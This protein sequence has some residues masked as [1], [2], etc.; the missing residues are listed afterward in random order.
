M[1]EEG[2]SIYV[3]N[4]QGGVPR[5]LTGEDSS[6]EMRPSYSR[7]GKWIYFG[8]NRSGQ[9]QVWKAHAEG[10]AA[11]QVT[12]RG[13]R[14]A[15]ESADGKFV[16]Y[17]KEFPI[18]GIW[19]VPA[20]GGE[21]TAVLDRG[22]QGVWALL[23]NG[24]CCWGGQLATMRPAVSVPAILFFPFDTGVIR[25]VT[26]LPEGTILNNGLSVSFDGRWVLYA[27]EEPSGSDI[28]LVEDFH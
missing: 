25:Q 7:D 16:Y 6:D 5:R 22:F 17:A 3:I 14:E 19:K 28:M 21:E 13:G 27:Q 15:F 10:G 8:S 20:A 24:I 2:S 12:R 9:W 18:E 26:A 4:A 23:E 11:V 1:G